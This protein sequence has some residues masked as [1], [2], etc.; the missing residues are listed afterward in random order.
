M[1]NHPYQHLHADNRVTIHNMSKANS[2]L[3]RNSS[4][5]AA[6][7]AGIVQ[8]VNGKTLPPKNSF[9]NAILVHPHPHT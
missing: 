2:T 7:F 1:Q 6:V 8:T 9:L 4:V 3:A 5:I